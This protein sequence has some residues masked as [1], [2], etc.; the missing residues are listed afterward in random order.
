MK[1][2]LKMTWKIIT[3]FKFDGSNKLK[4]VGATKIWKSKKTTHFFCW[5]QFLCEHC[6][7]EDCWAARILRPSNR[8]VNWHFRKAVS[9]RRLCET[10]TSPPSTVHTIFKR[11]RESREIT[12]STEQG[13]RPLAAGD[14]WALEQHCIKNKPDSVLEITAWIRNTSVTV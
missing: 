5:V 2:T 8:S 14:L 1:L 4:K 10:L 9:L 12:L 11:F 7:V 13:Q 6:S 3:I